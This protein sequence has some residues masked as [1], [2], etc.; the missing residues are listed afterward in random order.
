VIGSLPRPPALRALA[1]GRDDNAPEAPGRA[2]R[3]ALDAQVLEAIRLQERV[4]LDVVSDG[5]WRRT[6]YIRELLARVGGF[7]RCR[8]YR[9]RGVTRTTDVVV[10]RMGAHEPVFAEDARFLVRHATRCTKFALPSPFLIAV[11]YWDA[12]H[13]AGAYPTRQHFMDHAAEV[14]RREALALVEAGIDVVQLD[15]PALTYFCD[16]GLTSGQ[17]A[18]DERL[19]GDWDLDRHLPPALEAIGRV[20]EGLAAEVHL[21]CCHSV[22]KRASDVRGDYRPLLPRLAPLAVDRINLEFAYPDTGDLSDLELLP[23][24]FSVGLG[25]VDVRTERPQPVEAIEAL[26][27][28]GAAHVEPARIALNPDC[29]FAPDAGEPPSLE[30]A[31][32]KLER[33]CLAA[34]RLRARLAPPPPG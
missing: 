11:R 18:G 2:Y 23:P 17:G 15:D 7:E 31:R 29:G 3:E 32:L 8:T 16:R 20:T 9:H 27:A 13:S 34:A 14:L 28:A 12:A 1:S 5:E 21:H 33:L 6:H 25:V 10:R 30:E 22:H 24:H 19:G 4:G 26:A